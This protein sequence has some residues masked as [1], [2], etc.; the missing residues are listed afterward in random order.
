MAGFSNRGPTSDGRIKPDIVAPGTWIHSTKSSLKVHELDIGD[1]YTVKRGTSMATPIVAGSA[2][3]VIE[4]LNAHGYNCNLAYDSASDYC[5]DSA[6]VKAILSA[7]AHDMDGQYTS[8][9]DGLNGAAERA[10]NNHE[11]WGRVDL[12]RAMGSGFTE[13]IEITTDDSHSV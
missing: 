5:P 4:H 7:S 9:G 12:Q 2:A 3:L 1:Y 6:L 10:P 13:G 8:G 11:G